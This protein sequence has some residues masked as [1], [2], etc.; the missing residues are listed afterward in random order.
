MSEGNVENMC[1]HY[2]LNCAICHKTSESI[3]PSPKVRP[4][5]EESVPPPQ[6]VEAANTPPP[7]SKSEKK[8]VQ[9]KA[10]GRGRSKTP[11]PPAPPKT[12]DSTRAS[13]TCKRSV[14]CRDCMFVKKLKQN[15]LNGWRTII[16]LNYEIS[17]I[18]YYK[19]SS[20]GLWLTTTGSVDLPGEDSLPSHYV[21]LSMKGGP[22]GEFHHDEQ[23]LK[24][25]LNTLHECSL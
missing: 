14:G 24:G 20:G 7:E 23:R 6:H 25:Y 22:F 8:K 1:P 12:E 17:E 2:K 18:L 5:S 10:K 9:P 19:I 16:F 21:I 4:K 11:S 3:V 15:L 13:L